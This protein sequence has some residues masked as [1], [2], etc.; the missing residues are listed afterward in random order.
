[1]G[2]STPIFHKTL[3]VSKTDPTLTLF[4]SFL[5]ICFSRLFIF[6]CH[7]E[8]GQ[9]KLRIYFLQVAGFSPF[10]TLFQNKTF[11]QH[12]RNY[13]QV[14]HEN[15]YFLFC[16][17]HNFQI[18]LNISTN[19]LRL[20]TQNSLPTERLKS[21]LK[22]AWFGVSF[23]FVFWFSFPVNFYPRCR[24]QFY[25][26]NLFLFSRRLSGGSKRENV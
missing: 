24:L 6:R 18:R 7:N 20:T 11:G 19:A 21:D 13:C 23:L 26:R 1:M 12:T 3:E 10:K 5:L 25:R 2:C 14:T 17:C 4:I 22:L 16:C 15:L 8:N 9:M